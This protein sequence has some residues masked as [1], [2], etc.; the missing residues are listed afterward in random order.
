MERLLV[1]ASLALGA[2]ALP[3]AAQ[4]PSFDALFRTLVETDTTFETG[5][6][7]TAAGAMGAALRDGGFPASDIHAFAT[8][9][10]PREG[11]LVA[12]LPG[13]DRSAS[14]LLLVAHIDVVAATPADWASDPFKLTSAEGYYHGRGVSDNKAVA[15]AL[16]DTLLHLRAEGFRPRRTI[17]VALTCG[18]ETP[19]AFNGAEYLATTGRAIADAGLVLIPSGGGALDDRGRH[20][21]IAI[22]A[23][24]K[25]QQNFRLEAT[26]TGSHA[27]RPTGDNAIY[28]LAE[29]LTRIARLRFPV[30]LNDTTLAYFTRMAELAEPS[31]KRAITALLADPEDQAAQAVITADPAW[32]AM[33][34]T[35][36]VATIVETGRQA[37]TVAPRASANVNCRLLPGTTVEAVRLKLAETIADPAIDIAAAGPPPQPAQAPPVTRALLAPLEEV[38]RA[39]WP[40]VTIIPTMLTGATD[41]RHFNAAGIPAYGVTALFNDPDGNGVHAVDERVRMR[42]VDECRLFLDR[43]IR[44]FSTP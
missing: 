19:S 8:S 26:G 15:A 5:S 13:S 27:S 33:L 41:A 28:S 7:T 2:T 12:I 29:A 21:S 44:R 39:I 43:L 10:H 1:F 30:S 17:K 42:S 24:E 22:Q 16:I 20:V 25:V 9:D 14:A 34:R 38:V 23:G 11:G 40:D 3:V 32:N 18:E 36:C 4:P 31:R 35:T 37:N 6:C